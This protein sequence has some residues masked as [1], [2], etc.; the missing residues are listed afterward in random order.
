MTDEEQP[1]EPD[2]KALF[3]DNDKNNGNLSMA[4]LFTDRVRKIH[5]KFDIDKDGHLNFEELAAL[6]Q[7]TDGATLTKDMYVMA[8]RALDCQPSIGVSVGALKLTYASEGAD[9]SKWMKQD[10][11][12]AFFY[13][14][15]KKIIVDV[16]RFWGF[17][18]L[19]FAIRE[20]LIADK[21]YYKVFPEKKPKK[22]KQKKKDEDQIYEAGADGFDISD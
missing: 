4:E 7:T 12:Y 9:I 6:Q 15:Q 19:T 5:E 18:S 22:E 1:K 11:V 14:W 13:V 10:L 2:L 3:Q 20:L 8:C 21:D 17:C 16:F